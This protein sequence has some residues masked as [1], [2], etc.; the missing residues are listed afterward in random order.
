MNNPNWQHET[1]LQIPFHD[2][3]MMEVVW[4]GHYAK[5]IEIARCELLDKLNYNYPQMR[6]SN[7]SWPVID[8]RIKYVKPARFG[9][10]IK[11]H[12]QIT[13]YENRLRIDYVIYNAQTHQRLT[14]AYTIQVALEMHTQ[15]MCLASP[16]ILLEKLGLSI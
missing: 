12:S 16:P 6:D 11:V 13:E 2:V 9:D 5:Y 1:L 8:M 14:K 15:E 3:D 7:Y 10:Q 4:H